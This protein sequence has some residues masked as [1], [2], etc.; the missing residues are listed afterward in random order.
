[1]YDI[2][3]RLKDGTMQSSQHKMLSIIAVKHRVLK[4]NSLPN[5]CIKTK[6]NIFII[7]SMYLIIR[8]KFS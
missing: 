7:I 3:T 4:K 6:L 1:M 2:I 5:F 8:R